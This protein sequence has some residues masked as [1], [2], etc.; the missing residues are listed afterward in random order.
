MRKQ[1]DLPSE[2]LPIERVLSV[3]WSVELD[4]FGFSIVL[5]D[6]PLTRRGVLSTV[7]SVYDPLGFLAPLVVGAKKILQ[8]VC[9]KGISLDDPLP[10]E[11]R[12]RWEQWK[13]DFLRLRGLKIPRCFKPKMTG[14]GKTY[15]LHNFAGAS[16]FGYGQCSYL[17]VKDEDD[18]VNVALVAPRDSIHS[19]QVECS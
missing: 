2:Q 1:L 8:E 14:Q 7:A 17:R 4:C 19:L 5:K 6:Q 12:P 3:H 10:E 18:N 9:Q 16:T 13:I 11:L 15:E